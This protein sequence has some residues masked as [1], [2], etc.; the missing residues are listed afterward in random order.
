MHHAHDRP[1]GLE[2]RAL[3]QTD[4]FRDQYRQ[5]VVVEHRIGR[6]VQLGIRKSIFFGRL[7]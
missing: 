3:E 6:L 4:Y 7:G 2:A 5:R 1:E